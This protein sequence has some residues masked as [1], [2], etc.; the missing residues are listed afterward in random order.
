MDD[1]KKILEEILKP[2]H[3]MCHIID[4]YPEDLSSDEYAEYIGRIF[5]KRDEAVK[6]ILKYHRP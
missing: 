3:E 1:L 2:L 4:E 6:V 5:S